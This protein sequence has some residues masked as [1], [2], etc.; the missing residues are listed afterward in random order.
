MKKFLIRTLVGFSLIFIILFALTMLLEF[1]NKNALSKSVKVEESIVDGKIQIPETPEKVQANYEFSQLYFFSG[2]LISL[3]AP[4]LFYYFGGI[5]L[6]K[7]SKFKKKIVEGT[8]ICI[9]YGALSE[10]LLFPKVLFS[11]FYRAKLVGLSN[12][13]FLSFSSDF[14]KG[15]G[16]ELIFTLPVAV[17]IYLIFIKRERWYIWVSAILISVSLI[18]NYIY[19]YIDEF[20]NNLIDMEDGELKDKILDLSRDAG[21][22][23]LDIKIIPKSH[24]TQSMNAYMTGIHNS[25]RIVF[26]D[27]TLNKLSEKEILSVA[28]HEMGHYKLN[29]IQKSMILELIGTVILVLGIHLIMLKT[30]GKGYRTIDNIPRIILLLSIISILSAPIETACSRKAE[31]EADEFAMKVTHDNITNGLLELRF[32]ESNLTPIDVNSLYKWLA[33]DH[34]TVK[35]RIENSN[36]FK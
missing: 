16:E 23:N 9:L 2:T 3:G 30:K 14:V 34:P 18:S 8:A 35:E 17:I 28:A 24:K 5:E 31:V 19:P 32:V 11:S 29:H 1:K 22:E 12:Q 6:I 20:Q 26:W 27:T 33:Y 7:K 13:S 10:I 36:N 21:I 15:L 25:R 4:I